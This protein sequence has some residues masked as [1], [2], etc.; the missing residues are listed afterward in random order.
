VA[1]VAATALWINGV[2]GGSPAARPSPAANRL[3]TVAART[4]TPRAA[5]HVHPLAASPGSLPQTHAYPSGSSAQF[6]SLMA[7]LW[8][9][10][11]RDSL[12]PAL[13][14]F[15]PKDAYVQ[16]KAINSAG[17]DWTDRLVHDYRLD[18]AAAHALLGRDA[19]RARLVRVD[20]PSGY[21][22][23]IQP[24]VCYNSIGYY[25]MPNARVVYR[26][27][28]QIRSFGIASMISWRGVWYVVH[29][30]AILRSTDSGTVD[31]PS[32]GPGTS[33]YSG[34]C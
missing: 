15:F 6:K 8:A 34:T 27:D 31:D 7:S 10:I 30:G 12:T 22:H 9:G 14:A 4:R 23:W 5:P 20:V 26:E 13:A 19:I 18:I 11:V 17:S 25:E 2:S 21:G 29:L 3:R 28:G 16:L 1:T 32:S 24:G 33:A